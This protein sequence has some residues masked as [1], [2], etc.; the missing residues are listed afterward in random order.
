MP[1][2]AETASVEA[3][4]LQSANQMTQ[5]GRSEERVLELERHD[6]C[7]LIEGR[8]VVPN[9]RL[10]GWAGVYQV[11]VVELQCH[12]L[13]ADQ[14]VD[15]VRVIADMN[16]LGLSGEFGQRIRLS[17]SVEENENVAGLYDP[18]RV[19]PDA[20]TGAAA[21]F[22][23]DGVRAVVG[24]EGNKHAADGELDVVVSGPAI[25]DI[26]ARSD[27]D[28]II[29][30]ATEDGIVVCLSQWGNDT[31]IGVDHVIAAVAVDKIISQT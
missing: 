2:S 19:V 23:N 12:R 21:V 25:N 11:V 20:E 28:H 30:R 7:K 27:A 10:P 24:Y 13:I 15:F 9:Y 16:Q 3:A 18:N 17:V 26:L 8:K 6:R 31:N 29:A 4:G 1:T 5:I 14:P 22:E